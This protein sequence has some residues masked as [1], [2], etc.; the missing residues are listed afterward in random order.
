MA[1]RID[2]DL[3]KLDKAIKRAEK[4]GFDLRPA[5]RLLRKPLR[6]DQKAHMAAQQG[7]RGKWQALAA[8]TREKRMRV[9]G[10]AGKHTKRGKLKKSA[11][12]KLNRILSSKLLT[13]AKIKVRPTAISIRAKGDWAGVHQKGGRVGRGARVPARPFMWVSD[14]L[15]RAAADA[16]ARH[17]ATAF[18]GKKL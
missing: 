12:R 5:F 7:P 17:L 6:K 9:G 4:A 3:R 10:R 1:A 14:Q 2:V 16:F 15:G 18:N 13:G 8:A 11:Q